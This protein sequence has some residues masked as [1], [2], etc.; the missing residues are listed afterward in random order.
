MATSTT[1]GGD[2]RPSDEAQAE[3]EL[4]AATPGV[5][6]EMVELGD[7]VS[8]LVSDISMG[9]AYGDPALAVTLRVENRGAED[10]QAPNVGIRCAGSID[11][12][13]EVSEDT[14]YESWAELP[15]GSFAE[16]V[17]KVVPPSDSVCDTPAFIWITPPLSFDDFAVKI[18][19]DDSLI[20]QLN[21]GS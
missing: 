3:K 10:A 18:P 8:V 12:G 1:I 4:D 21:A 13:M 14:T 16:G 9:E 6:G 20:A 17:T 11:D 7:G 2:L 19:I 5:I 15:S